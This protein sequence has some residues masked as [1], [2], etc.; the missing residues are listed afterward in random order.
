VEEDELSHF[1]DYS[2]NLL[3]IFQ[4]EDSYWEYNKCKRKRILTSE[5]NPGEKGIKPK[6]PKEVIYNQNKGYFFLKIKLCNAVQVP[7]I[8]PNYKELICNVIHTPS[9]S[10]FWHFSIRWQIDGKDRKSWKSTAI[11]NLMLTTGRSFLVEIAETSI[12][13]YFEPEKELYLVN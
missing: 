10:N 13:N 6:V 4:H 7:L 3:G 8:N 2:T 1:R 11:K 9:K 5:W 12:P